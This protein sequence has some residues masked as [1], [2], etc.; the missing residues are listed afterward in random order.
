MTGMVLAAAFLMSLAVFWLLAGKKIRLQARSVRLKDEFIET[1][2]GP[3]KSSQDRLIVIA[4]GVIM[5]GAAL[6]V[7]GAWYFALAGLF[8]GTFILRWWK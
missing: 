7:T 5:G 8:S 2:K 3:G 4:G 6:A 1:R